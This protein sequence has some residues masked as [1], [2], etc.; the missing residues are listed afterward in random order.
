MRRSE[1]VGGR[2]IG[3]LLLLMLGLG[4][5]ARAQFFSP[6][7]LAKSHA[8]LDTKGLNQCGACHDEGES[9]FASRCLACHTELG[10]EIKKRDGLHGR[11]AP[12]VLNQC[13]SC[14]PDHRG[15]DFSLISFGG[16]VKGFDHKRTGWPLRG[17]HAQTSCQSCHAIHQL[18]DQ[19]VVQM[20]AAQPGR[21]TFLGLAKRCDSCHFDEHRGQLGKD[22]QKCH[23]DTA[24]FWKTTLGAFDHQQTAFPLRGKH[25]PVPCA[26]CHATVEDRAS[27]K[28][29]FPSPPSPK[30]MQMKPVAHGTCES[31]HKDPHKGSFG[32]N[33]ASCHTEDGWNV[34]LPARDLAPG[35]HDR[36]RFPLRGAH[37]S[38]ACKS[39][40]GPFGHQPAIFRGLTFARCSDCHQDAHVGQLAA[41][42]GRPAAD[43]AACHD[44]TA[45]TPPRYEL[46]THAKTRFPLEGGHAVTPCRD[47]HPNDKS[48]LAHLPDEVRAKLARQHRP[49]VVSLAVLRPKIAA[50]ACSRCHKDPHEG[51]FD[52][53]I[54]KD[55]CGGCHTVKSFADMT[56]FQHDRD[57][58]F[59]LSG[60]HRRAPC[61]SCHR[62]EQVRAGEA[63]VVIRWKPLPI[64]CGGCHRDEHQG[65][66]LASTLPSDGLARRSEE[67]DFCHQT[68]TFKQTGFR[69][70]GARFT[71]Y[72][73][74]GKHARLPCGDCHRAVTLAAEGRSIQTVRYRP[75]PR[76]CEGCHLDFHHGDFK[77]FEP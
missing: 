6:G 44:E 64:S 18:V 45:F 69:H 46:E 67:C 60:A 4:H 55:D 26:G 57:S 71:S 24:L 36:T 61:G 39:C 14:H 25:K 53:E 68:T 34:I 21:T 19:T 8:T 16:S 59:P 35:F 15:R 12:A 20:L 47:C 37:T 70:D 56:A 5:N 50:E 73:L 31:C 17:L 48:L 62:V 7:P 2:A 72:A 11:M 54:K 66:F 27:G 42:P 30:F 58:R 74:L 3:V 22:C 33:C 65:Q 28:Q 63:P 52:A 51:Q 1:L 9:R 49:V 77:G 29:S 76:A 75:L 13:Q 23:G 10:P 40:H 41:L 38:V 32:P 43:C